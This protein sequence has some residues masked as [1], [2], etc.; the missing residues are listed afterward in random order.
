MNWRVQERV[1]KM[2]MGLEHGKERA[3]NYSAWRR[4]GFGGMCSSWMVP[5]R[6]AL[7]R[8]SQ[9]T[10]VLGGNTRQDINLNRRGSEWV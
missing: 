9:A 8:Q 5:L 3:R 7:R 1:I 10:A 4:E 2:V 6:R